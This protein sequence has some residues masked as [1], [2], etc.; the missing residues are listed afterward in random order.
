MPGAPHTATATLRPCGFNETVVADLN[1][2]KNSQAM[3]WV[4]LSMMDA[5]TCWHVA[6]LL[7]NRKPRHVARKMIEG[8]IRHYGCPRYL[9]AD[10]GGDFEGH[11]NDKC[12]ELGID[13]SVTASHAA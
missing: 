2:A 8:W 3:T 11:F 1:Y 5:G 6:V 10:Q 13:A 9:I 12:D 7:R 4:A